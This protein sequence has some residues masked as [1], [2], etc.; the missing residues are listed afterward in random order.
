MKVNSVLRGFTLVELLVVIAII[1]TLVGILLPAIQGARESARQLQ[2]TN[3]LKQLSTAIIE[4]STSSKG[5][6]PGWMQ[7]QRT[8]PGNDQYISG[9]ANEP[10]DV[11]VSWAAKLLTRIEQQALW[12]QILTNNDGGAANG[13]TDFDYLSPPPLEVFVC[14]NDV[15][16]SAQH[17]R[18]TYIANSGTPDVMWGD[19][20]DES[21][22]IK[23]NGM[24]HDLV[25]DNVKLKQTD[26]K[27][28]TATT[29]LLSENIHK[30]DGT[31]S[32]GG[33]TTAHTWLNSPLWATNSRPVEQAYG[34]TWFYESGT[35][36]AA[37]Y[38]T[39]SNPG[40]RVEQFNRENPDQ[41]M[42]YVMHQNGVPYIRPASDHPGVF[43]VTFVG[44]NTR[45][46]SQ[47]VDYRIYQ[48]LLTPNGAKAEFPNEDAIQMRQEFG[49]I[50]LSDDQY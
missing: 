39:P 36:P 35:P 49:E 18:L 34:M 24:C 13:G 50:Q 25:N 11:L 23:E 43:N 48:Q 28:G 3:N 1:G 37:P 27:D 15:K 29:L 7:A 42:P 47:D 9:Q 19:E 31:H 21:N 17:G 33:P 26:I 2:C 32:I 4:L 16:P 5:R 20:D 8:Q 6:Y 46:I 41:N 30:D 10:D 12:D 45:T 44:G 40:G 22:D 14:P 38:R